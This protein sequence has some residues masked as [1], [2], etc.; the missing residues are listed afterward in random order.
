[1]HRHGIEHPCLCPCEQRTEAHASASTSRSWRA[2]SCGSWHSAHGVRGERSC[3][4]LERTRN[5]EQTTPMSSVTQNTPL[6]SFCMRLRLW[7]KTRPHKRHAILKDRPARGTVRKCHFKIADTWEDNDSADHML[8]ESL[9]HVLRQMAGK[10]L[11][12]GNQND[13]LT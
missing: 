1:M 12:I 2:I 13:C 9:T 10:R 7:K 8:R 6:N 3:T 11:I 4:R 5:I